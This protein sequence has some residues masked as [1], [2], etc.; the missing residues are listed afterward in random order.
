MKKVQQG[1]EQELFEN[2]SWKCVKRMSSN[3]RAVPLLESVG[4]EGRPWAANGSPTACSTK[5]PD[6]LAWW[7]EPGTLAGATA[8]PVKPV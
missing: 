2:S 6:T 5:G 8:T 4:R 3:E 1:K 7:L